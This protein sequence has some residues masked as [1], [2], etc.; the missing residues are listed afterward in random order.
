VSTNDEFIKNLIDDEIKK[1]SIP[2]GVKD[3]IWHK[4]EKNTVQD[5][6]S[7][8]R[9]SFAG[10]GAAVLLIAVLLSMPDGGTASYFM[11]WIQQSDGDTTQLMAGKRTHSP[12]DPDVPPPPPSDAPSV[13]FKVKE[14]NK[15]TLKA[16]SKSL[17]EAQQ[18]AKFDIRVPS[19]IPEGYHFAFANVFY[20]DGE[21]SDR[22][23]L[24]LDKGDQSISIEQRYFENDFGMG[25]GFGDAYME[26]A[27]INGNDAQVIIYRDKSVKIMWLDEKV[28][29]TIEGVGDK[30]Q[31]LEMA[32]SL[33]EK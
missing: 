24:R 15:R 22:V 14:L 16:E 7:K 27:N 18:M 31:L 17:E 8:W 29:I 2:N 3:D 25:M 20:Y 12:T 1:I 26:T 10:F 13:E 6:P 28:F 11:K 32:K 30:E 33:K 23:V 5:K 19:F 21:K 9:Y 4:I